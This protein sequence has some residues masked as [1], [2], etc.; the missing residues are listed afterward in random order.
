M[1]GGYFSCLAVRGFGPV[2]PA[3]FSTLR[4]NDCITDI[5]GQ[6]FPSIATYDQMVGSM[7]PGTIVNVGYRHGPRRQMVQLLVGD[8]GVYEGMFNSI[9]RQSSFDSG[10]GATA[11]EG[12]VLAVGGPSPFR[13]GDAVYG[14]DGHRF[15]SL[16]AMK[17]YLQLSLSRLNHLLPRGEAHPEIMQATAE[18]HHQVADAPLP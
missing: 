2:G 11:A 8:G 7:R 1:N 3:R 17:A 13:P 16:G 6:L 18:F 9:M 5:N 12:E 10:N 14:V 15:G 4:V